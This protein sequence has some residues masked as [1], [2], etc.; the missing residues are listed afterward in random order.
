MSKNLKNFKLP[1]H[2]KNISLIG[3]T[4][5]LLPLNSDKYYI[6]L[7]SS[8][9]ID[10][11]GSNWEYLPYGPFKTKIT[12]LEW[13]KNIENKNDPVFFVV[14]RKSDNKAVGLTSFMRINIEYGVIEVGHINFSPLIQK[15]LEGTE[16]MFLMMNWV[17]ENGFR[18]Y[19]WKCNSENIRSR[20]AAQ[21]LGFSYEGV[22]RQ[23]SISKG[24]NRNTA[25][26][27]AIDKEWGDL[28]K[29]YKVY[30]DK[31]NF[32]NGNQIK[33]LSSLTEKI[34]YKKDNLEFTNK[35]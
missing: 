9:L 31:N 22:F 23:M 8:Q 28:R 21:R 3:K 5:N 14:I 24:K 26:F 4:V 32:H 6:D 33:S 13:L 12:Y 16:T 25:W 35:Y 19:E 15:T 2:P 11:E 7:Y 17:F 34:L 10:K 29:A 18:R 1:P 30:F 27:A 20:K